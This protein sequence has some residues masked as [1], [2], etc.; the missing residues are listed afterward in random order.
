[1]SQIKRLTGEKIK[2]KNGIQKV[3]KAVMK[4]KEKGSKKFSLD[5]RRNRFIINGKIFCRE[6]SQG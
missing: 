4:D 5:S 6:F 1:M 3:E 2:K